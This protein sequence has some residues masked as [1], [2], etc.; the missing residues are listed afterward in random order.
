MFLTFKHS[1]AHS[2]VFVVAL[3]SWLVNLQGWTLPGG[4]M[5]RAEVLFDYLTSLSQSHTPSRRL[6]AKRAGVTQSRS[7]DS[8]DGDHQTSLALAVAAGRQRVMAYHRM[9]GGYRTQ[10]DV[11]GLRRFVERHGVIRSASRS[12]SGVET[13]SQR[14]QKGGR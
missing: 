13:G 12:G 8:A 5:A 10:G 9:C 14:V 2:F 7:P 1:Y 3:D 4:D 6:P 11:E